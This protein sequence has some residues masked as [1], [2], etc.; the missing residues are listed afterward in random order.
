MDSIR[1]AM[2]IQRRC[3]QIP[4][5]RGVLD[6]TLFGQ[7][8]QWLPTGRWFSLCTPVSSTNKTSLH[9]IAEILLKVTLNII[10]LTVKTSVIVS[11]TSCKF[12]QIICLHVFFFVLWCPVRFPRKNVFTPICFRGLCFIY[13]ICIYLYIYWCL[14]RFPYQ[15]MFESFNNNTMGF[16]SGAEIAYTSGAPEFTP[17]IC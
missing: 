5:R 9:D 2:P 11:F 12:V 6:T 1:Y 8:C 10:T 17:V 3:V 16:T 15:M 14:T 4:L 7:V 13:V